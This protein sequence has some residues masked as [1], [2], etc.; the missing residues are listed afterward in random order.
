MADARVQRIERGIADQPDLPATYTQSFTATA[1]A[2]L[3]AW[4]EIAERHHDDGYG[5]CKEHG[6]DNWD[7]AVE[8]F[9]CPDRAAADAALDRLDAL[10]G[11]T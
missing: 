9:P 6:Y 3:R 4:Q 7:E 2:D 1:L 11:T 5:C 8:E 10:W